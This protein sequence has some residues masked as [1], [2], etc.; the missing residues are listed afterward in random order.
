MWCFQPVNRPGERRCHSID[1]ERLQGTNC[2]N[3]TSKAYG[4]IIIIFE[5]LSMKQDA[6]NEAGSNVTGGQTVL[7]PWITIGGV[8]SSVCL[9][10]EIIMPDAAV[11]GDVLVLTKPLGTQLA[12][13]AYQWMI[14]DSD[15]W[16]K[17]QSK[18]CERDI[19]KMYHRAMDSMQR[20][21][22]TGNFK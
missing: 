20:L 13:L 1:D 18:F 12:S 9:P 15:K 2:F 11:A 3:T 22:R 17:I 4:K 6:A 19:R 14:T 5:F 10:G 16:K 8:A 7:N 21:N